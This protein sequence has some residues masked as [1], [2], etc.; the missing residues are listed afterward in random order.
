MIMKTLRF[1]KFQILSRDNG[2]Y[3]SLWRRDVIMNFYTLII[4]QFTETLFNNL[5]QSRLIYYN[6][7][8]NFKS[9][10]FKNIFNAMPS[11]L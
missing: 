7:I 11:Y 5:I 10:N 3:E 2:Y 8:L 4:L 1:L 6:L 9:I